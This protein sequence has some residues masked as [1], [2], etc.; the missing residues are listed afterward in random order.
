MLPVTDAVQLAGTI[1]ATA[2]DAQAF[3]GD[4]KTLARFVG[5]VSLI[6]QALEDLPSGSTCGSNGALHLGTAEGVDEAGPQPKWAE[7]FADLR[8]ALWGCAELVQACRSMG[9]LEAVLQAEEMHTRFNSAAA[10]L[11][12]AVAGL[13]AVKDLA[14]EDVGEDVGED[15]VSL[16]AQL[17]R[18]RFACR[19]WQEQLASNLL[20]A[21]TLLSAHVGGQPTAT[22]AAALLQQALDAAGL[23]VGSCAAWLEREVGRL[24]RAA[25][26]AQDAE[27]WIGEYF[28]KLVIVALLVQCTASWEWVQQQAAGMPC[29]SSSTPV[30]VAGAAVALSSDSTLP[31]S[32]GS[33]TAE[34]V[35]GAGPVST[36][37]G[38]SDKENGRSVDTTA[39]AAANGVAGCAH[40][41]GPAAEQAALA[42]GS[43]GAERVRRLLAAWFGSGAR[44]G[45]SS[46]PPLADTPL[47]L[48][49]IAA[50]CELL[51]VEADGGMPAALQTVDP[52]NL[53]SVVAGLSSPTLLTQFVAA[54]VVEHTAEDGGEAGRAQLV[55][56][57][58]IPALLRV[59]QAGGGSKHPTL[60]G[61]VATAFRHLARDPG[62]RKRIA[63]AGTI[64]S[65]VSLLQNPSAGTRQ[66]AARALSNLVVNSGENKLEA[67]KFG[68]VHS[69]V[70]MLEPGDSELSREAAAA[71][72]GNMA[73]NSEEAQALI[74]EAGAILLLTGVLASGTPAARQHAARALRNLAGRDNRNKLQTV[75]AG[76]IPLLVQ[77]IHASCEVAARQA[78]ASAL[79]NIACN[80]E[81]AQRQI[82]QAGALPVLCEM[83]GCGPQACACP[84]GTTD[85]SAGES[86]GGSE[87]GAKQQH[88]E[89]VARAASTPYPAHSQPPPQEHAQGQLRA[90]GRAVTSPYPAPQQRDPTQGCREA[91]AWTLSNLAC[92]AEVR[93][94]IAKHE[95]AL[96]RAGVPPGSSVVGGLVELLR[97][98][99]ES[100]RQAACRALKN[101]A[102][103]HSNVY[104]VR[105][106]EAGAIPPLVALLRSPSEATRK[107][108]A[109]ALW[110][111]AYRN[112][113][114]RR[115]ITQAGAIPPL[116]ELLRPG[117]NS[118]G[119]RQ[120][121]AR[122]LSNL[123]CNNDENQGLEMER[124]GAVPLLVAMM[125]P[126]NPAAARE[127]AAGAISNLACIKPNQAAII[128][129]GAVPHLL[130]LLEPGSTPGCQEAAARGFGNLVCD[131]LGD[132]LRPV[133]YR[134]IPLLVGVAGSGSDGARQ[135]AARALSNLAC[136]DPTT[137]GMVARSGGPAAL[138]ALC[139]S[140][141]EELREAAATAL[142]D[143]AYDSE[144]GRRAVAAAGAVPW[145][146]QLLLFGGSG[147]KEAAA[148]T[149][150]ELAAVGPAVQREISDAGA[151]QLLRQLARG[152][153]AEVALAATEALRALEVHSGRRSSGRAPTTAAVDQALGQALAATAAA[154]QAVV[155]ALAGVVET[156]TDL[157]RQAADAAALP[158]FE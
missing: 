62:S 99:S 121:A 29:S 147:A 2:K 148:A 57:K 33:G 84:S 87:A 55:S 83:L 146:A 138:V 108:A 23:D 92:S 116:V 74:A 67:V 122:A 68:A 30:S 3:S 65:L 46:L 75:E 44:G 118:Q 153:N 105:I 141:N 63:E 14:P 155:S 4:C 52:H 13:T 95:A 48:E 35:G 126:G 10:D 96:A 51:R 111:L 150:A 123:S 32:G 128:D 20:R 45:G 25:K 54:V 127:A 6:L 109:S 5:K 115:A 113:A 77:L 140:P 117:H 97:V 86:A 56:L 145:L 18:L 47:S 85:G 110:N 60:R 102:A 41:G 158:G 36:A 28:C 133:A 124:E 27:D 81:E 152:D 50:V 37:S 131:N 69:L 49:T 120:E 7:L 134:A 31:G 9:C 17:A 71:A 130:S 112:N 72:L 64:P 80:C 93:A 107:A 136:S 101:L 91:A 88:P 42:A 39:A 98:G 106:A 21:L 129:A 104:K 43:P 94:A 58:A 114:N 151:V 143:V 119:C 89:F 61:V 26:A 59:L 135:A 139:Q 70:R 73:A 12:L 142:W 15:I 76:A 34:G 144:E 157:V 125:E 8:D 100:G 22:A 79:S 66:A 40:A 132:G 53:N 149:L 38:A 78:A 103:G 82:A 19:G 137:Q 11:G 1:A 154:P 90:T 16:R 24:Q 156:A